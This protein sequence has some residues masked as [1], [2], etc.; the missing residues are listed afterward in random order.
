MVN[1]IIETDKYT[2]KIH[3]QECLLEYIV[4][5]GVKLDVDELLEGK[6]ALTKLRPG[7]R[8]FVLAEGIEFFTISKEARDLCA[9]AEYSDNTIAIAF[10]TPNISLL[11]M[12][13]MYNKINKPAVPT[14]IFSQRDTAEEWLR[15]QMKK[16]K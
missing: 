10:Y 16:L 1:E 13:E 2:M 9:T 15:E 6:K 7:V 3:D 5:E 11:L 12:G 14:K 4:K 8:F